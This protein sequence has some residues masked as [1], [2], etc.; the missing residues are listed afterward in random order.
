MTLQVYRAL[1][2]LWDK[3]GPESQEAYSVRFD[4]FI[5]HQNAREAQLTPAHVLALRFYTTHAFK[6]LNGPLRDVGRYG[7]G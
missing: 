7:Q 5:N 6:Y 1:R 3:L 4:N 2:P